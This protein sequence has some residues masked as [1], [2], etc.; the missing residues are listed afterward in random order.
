[1]A[2]C[3]EESRHR[4]EDIDWVPR[5]ADDLFSCELSAWVARERVMGFSDPNRIIPG[6]FTWKALVLMP[7][8][9][10]QRHFGAG[11]NTGNLLQNFTEERVAVRGKEANAIIGF[12]TLL[13]KNFGLPANNCSASK[14][15]F[16]R[17]SS[18]S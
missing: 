16:E 11:Q 6:L 8:C 7:H 10:I 14:L 4:R 2:V 15:F 17:R 9:Y 13:S 5:Y 1:M 12:E 3:Q 18:F